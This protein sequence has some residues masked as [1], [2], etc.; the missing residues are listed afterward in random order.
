M[1]YNMDARVAMPDISESMLRNIED[2]GLSASKCVVDEEGFGASDIAKYT[3]GHMVQEF[4]S[5]VAKKIRGVR[6]IRTL[7]GKY[8]AFMQG[9]IYARCVMSVEYRKGEM[10][11]TVTARTI[12]S[13]NMKPHHYAY[14][15]K[16]SSRLNV[17]VKNVVTNFTEVSLHEIIMHHVVKARVLSDISSSADG[18]TYNV[19]RATR[20]LGDDVIRAE[21]LRIAESGYTFHDGEVTA[22]V[23]A[24]RDAV[25]EDKQLRQDVSTGI[26]FVQLTDDAVYVVPFD[27]VDQTYSAYVSHSSPARPT[28]MYKYG[29][30]SDLPEELQGKIALLSMQDSS[31]YLTAVGVVRDRYSYFLHT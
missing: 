2:N 12:H 9:D 26:T 16:M 22:R 15:R 27:S 24:Y 6:F 1:E 25:A 4:V 3:H 17:A 29:Q 19:H 13:G 5:A 31:E 20:Q 8:M 11:Y 10:V 7:G 18:A 30:V 28:H 21:L 14:D 23:Q